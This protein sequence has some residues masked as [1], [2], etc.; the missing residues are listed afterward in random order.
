M[1]CFASPKQYTRGSAKQPSCCISERPEFSYSCHLPG[2]ESLHHFKDADVCAQRF[3]PAEPQP[4]ALTWGLGSAGRPL[5]GCCQG[6]SPGAGPDTPLCGSW[7]EITH[8]LAWAATPAIRADTDPLRT[9]FDFFG[10][11][12]GVCRRRVGMMGWTAFAEIPCGMVLPPLSRANVDFILTVS[13]LIHSEDS[14]HR[15]CT[16]RQK[17]DVEKPSLGPESWA[18]A[19]LSHSGV[20]PHWP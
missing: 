7:L 5:P 17:R 13:P 6:G 3:I 10:H 20:R 2:K 12:E 18:P 4:A 8:I 15:R 9:V 11:W 19:H 1:G 14:G 16:V